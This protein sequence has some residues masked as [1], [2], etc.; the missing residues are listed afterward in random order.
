MNYIALNHQ[1]P[2]PHGVFYNSERK[3]GGIRYYQESKSQVKESKDKT[4]V[5]VDPEKAKREKE[6]NLERRLSYRKAKREARRQAKEAKKLA[7][8]EEKR[9]AKL[10][11]ERDRYSVLIKGQE[12]SFSEIGIEPARFSE[13]DREWIEHAH[14]YFITVRENNKAIGSSKDYTTIGVLEALWS[15]AQTVGIDPKRYI[16]QVFNESRFDPFAKGRAGE[17]GIGQFKHSTAK[18]HGY[19]WEQM[20]SGIEGFAYQA[21]A[22]AEFVKQVGEV[23]YNGKGPRAQRYQG[24]INSRLAQIDTLET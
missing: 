3:I 11:E 8:Q 1:A 24:K 18:Y 6:K 7:K 20:T 23:S 17:R 2:S 14:D 4:I 5:K 9:L 19:D 12:V 22:A 10:A 16:V 15:T 13:S 21:K